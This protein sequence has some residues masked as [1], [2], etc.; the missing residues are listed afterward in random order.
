MY[1]HISRTCHLSLLQARRST[2][3]TFTLE[4]TLWVSVVYMRY[5]PS[6]NEASCRQIGSTI[7][8]DIRLEPPPPTHVRTHPHPP[9][10]HLWDGDT[11]KVPSDDVPSNDVPS[12][13]VPSNEVPHTGDLQRALEQLPIKWEQ[14]D[15]ERKVRGGRR[16]EIFTRMEMGS[17]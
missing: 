4:M 15:L 14:E 10:A 11:Y 12:N 2:P 13:E 9:E 5:W 3:T 6:S 8:I 1:L 17:C 7:L 16:V